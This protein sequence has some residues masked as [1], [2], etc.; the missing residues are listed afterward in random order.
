MRSPRGFLAAIAFLLAIPIALPFQI[1][2]GNGAETIIHL[3]CGVGFALSSLAVFDFKLPRWI[4]WIGFVSTSASAFIFLLQGVSD[5]I[6]NDALHYLAFQVLGQ[7]LERWLI[8]LFI[9]WFV[10]MLL[11]D[12]QGTTRVFGIVAMSIVVFLEVYTYSLSLLG[13]AAAGSLKLVYFL[14]FVWFLFESRK[15]IPLELKASKS[16]GVHP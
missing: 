10:A 9:F 3:V 16:P 4:T 11:I 15:K 12:S 7:G 2:F 8:D 13:G 6:Q 1:I 5:L 14:A